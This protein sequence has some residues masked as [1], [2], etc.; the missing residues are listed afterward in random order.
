VLADDPGLAAEV[1]RIITLGSPHHGTGLLS[2]IRFG[3]V[4]EMMSVDSNFIKGLPDFQTSAPRAEVTTVAS[5]QDL[6]V[7]PVATCYL[8]GSR[9]IT[10]NGIGHLGLLTEK[11]VMGLVA[12]ALTPKPLSP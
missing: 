7:Y 4:Y 12:E 11:K 2:W 1:R 9:K 6:I 5:E 10:L 8:K 3:P